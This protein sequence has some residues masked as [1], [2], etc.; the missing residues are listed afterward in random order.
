MDYHGERTVKG[1]SGDDKPID[2]TFQVM[3]VTKPLGSMYRSL[4]CG[5]TVV[6]SKGDSKVVSRQ[7]LMAVC[8]K[9]CKIRVAGI[10]QALYAATGRGQDADK[11]G[12]SRMLQRKQKQLRQ[13]CCTQHNSSSQ[14]RTPYAWKHIW[15]NIYI[16]I[17]TYILYI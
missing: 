3:D 7:E 14:V 8:S 4:Q 5:N 1:L 11:L 6:F 13:G 15:G 9:Y 2:M 12:E 17:Y 10:R 16:Y